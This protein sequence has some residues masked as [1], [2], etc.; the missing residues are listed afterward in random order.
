MSAGLLRADRAVRVVGGWTRPP[1]TFP[2]DPRFTIIRD[3][4]L[5]RVREHYD[6]RFQL[7]LPRR[8][9]LEGMATGKQTRQFDVTRLGL[10]S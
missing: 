7:T 5:G 10:R 3:D 8:G 2:R 4:S 6:S 1:R 9:S